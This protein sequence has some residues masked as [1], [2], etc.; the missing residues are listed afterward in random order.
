MKIVTKMVTKWRQILLYPKSWYK[1]QTCC[2][3]AWEE[4]L[5]IGMAAGLRPPMPGWGARLKAAMPALGILCMPTI[6][7]GRGTGLAVTIEAALPETVLP[8]AWNKS[9]FILSFHKHSETWHKAF[10]PKKYPILWMYTQEEIITRGV[11][12]QKVLPEYSQAK[13][14]YLRI[15]TVDGPKGPRLTQIYC[16]EPLSG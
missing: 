11:N 12:G 13:V 2:W 16:S 9:Q 6:G 5:C 15:Q 7:I 3:W 8:V 14:Q 4:F 10:I 1:N